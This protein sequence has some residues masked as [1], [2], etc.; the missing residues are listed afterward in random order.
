MPGEKS[1]TLLILVVLVFAVSYLALFVIIPGMSRGQKPVLGPDQPVGAEHIQWIVDSLGTSQ[2][3]TSSITGNPPEIEMIVTPGDQFFT[4][5]I[6]NGVAK[7]RPGLADDPDIR[8]TGGR[9]VI[10]ELLE[11]SDLAG[12]AR[13][14]SGEG[15][16][17]VDVLKDMEDIEDM[18]YQALYQSLT[19]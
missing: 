19:S 10:A 11:T 1:S 12:T 15:R 5:T 18:G 6:R 17:Q 13:R 7:V 2:L 4:L 3:R 8:M 16:V 9:D 14:L